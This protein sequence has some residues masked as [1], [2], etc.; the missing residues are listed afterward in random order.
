MHFIHIHTPTHAYT[1]VRPHLIHSTLIHMHAF[2]HACILRQSQWSCSLSMYVR[3]QANAHT[4]THAHS[5]AVT[6]NKQLLIN[7]VDE[8]HAYSNS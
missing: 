2:E 3:K 6:K 8:F 7:Y 4:H 5:L 1:H